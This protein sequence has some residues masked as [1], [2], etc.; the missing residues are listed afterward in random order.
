MESVKPLAIPES[1]HKQVKKAADKRGM[2]IKAL[3]VEI[4]TS[5]VTK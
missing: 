3:V 4:L 2:T 1:L 5:A